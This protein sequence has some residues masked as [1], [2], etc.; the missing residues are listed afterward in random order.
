MKLKLSLFPT[1]KQSRSN[2]RED[3]GVG[4]GGMMKSSQGLQM[5]KARERSNHHGRVS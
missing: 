2:Q 5:S 4:A 3:L 1:S